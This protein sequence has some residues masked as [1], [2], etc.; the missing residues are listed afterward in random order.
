MVV[1]GPSV[2]TSVEPNKE[3]INEG[4]DHYTDVFN[5]RGEVSVEVVRRGGGPEVTF[6]LS[7]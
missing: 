7:P 2:L 5:D 1:L 6:Y 4:R 3:D